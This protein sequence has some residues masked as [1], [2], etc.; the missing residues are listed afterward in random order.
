MFVF[1]RVECG[2]AKTWCFGVRAWDRAQLWA[3][4]Y[5]RT[6]CLDDAEAARSRRGTLISCKAPRPRAA[7]HMA[8]EEELVVA[9]EVV[10]TPASSENIVV[11]D[12]EPATPRLGFWAAGLAAAAG[13]RARRALVRAEPEPEGDQMI[14]VEPGKKAVGSL[15]FIGT[16]TEHNKKHRRLMPI[17]IDGGTWHK[18]EEL[19][20]RFALGKL[21]DELVR[22]KVSSGVLA[23]SCWTEKNK[24]TK[25]DGTF[26]G[27][28]PR[29]KKV[30]GISWSARPDDERYQRLGLIS[31]QAP[32]GDIYFAGFDGVISPARSWETKNEVYRVTL[33]SGGL[34]RWKWAGR[35][36]PLAPEELY[37]GPRDDGLLSTGEISG[38]YYSGRYEF[39]SC[40]CCRSMTVMPH[41]PD[42]IETWISGCC[43]FPPFFMGIPFGDGR[44]ATREPGTNTF[45]DR[46]FSAD[47]MVENENRGDFLCDC[48][49]F[50]YKKRPNSRA[51]GKVETR[52]L[53]GTWCGCVFIP[54][55]VPVLGFT[56][57]TTKTALNEDQYTEA[58]CY[59][60]LCAPVFPVC[61]TH[62]RLYEN[63]HATNGFANEKLNG[64]Y[65]DIVW[66]RD[67]GYT[68]RGEEIVEFA[69]KLC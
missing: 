45:D 22:N 50:P 12:A 5:R 37:T 28:A 65:L 48:E 40:T 17:K 21:V 27:N 34:D 14:T 53:A 42:A 46:T 7:D 69:K 55:V 51:F 32:L 30:W 49:K 56:R 67:A 64:A 15:E 6:D 20:I 24:R 2:A 54:V 60:F 13:A 9:G 16:W 44:V 35:P 8:E 57:C 25:P 38:E 41:G 59:F 61:N 36:P 39:S 58:G 26:D 29:T 3:S 33:P 1:A 62:T 63:G 68:R 11:V 19:K 4:G 10:T 52:D 66:Y 18:D 47:G 43:F 31:M 23:I